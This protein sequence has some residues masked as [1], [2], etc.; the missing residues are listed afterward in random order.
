[1]IEVASRCQ[2]PVASLAARRASTRRG[3]IRS[4]FTPRPM[5]ASSA[6]N[7]VADA[8]IDT[9]GTSRPPTPIERMNGSGMN[10]RS[11]SPI[12]TVMPEKSVA[13]PAVAIVFCRASGASS[14]YASSSR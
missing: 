13:R 11:A 5:I 7:S 12:A 2:T 3:M 6:G 9:T 10:T 1:M 4:R 14:V 8:A